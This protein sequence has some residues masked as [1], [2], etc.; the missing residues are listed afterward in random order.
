MQT[1]IYIL[2]FASLRTGDDPLDSLIVFSLCAKTR[3]KLI[4]HSLLVGEHR[5]MSGLFRPQSLS[6]QNFAL[7]GSETMDIIAQKR[8]LS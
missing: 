8:R 7:V 1:S 3:I 5:S 6:T 4:L 2:S